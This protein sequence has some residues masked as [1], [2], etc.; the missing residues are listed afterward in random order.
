MSRKKHHRI[1]GG[2]E[3]EREIL[4]VS[5]S[6]KMRLRYT[7]FEEAIASVVREG[8]VGNYYP[9]YPD[10]EGAC[11]LH[12]MIDRHLILNKVPV[13]SLI[14]FPAVRTAADVH[15]STDALVYLL[16]ETDQQFI[17]TLDIFSASRY[18]LKRAK[19]DKK[20]ISLALS[21]FEIQNRLYILKR[22]FSERVCGQPR[23]VK[24]NPRFWFEFWEEF[25]FRCASNEEKFKRPENWFVLTDINAGNLR[26]IESLGELIAQSLMSQMKKIGEPLE[27]VEVT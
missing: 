15:F 4:L 16:T 3:L 24:C 25:Q 9:R 10:T 2:Q 12:S 26:E 5:S 11:L 13:K 8:L 6:S 1:K 27:K 19:R 22:L 7:S 20:N 21:Y 23:D 17:A 18:L 14:L